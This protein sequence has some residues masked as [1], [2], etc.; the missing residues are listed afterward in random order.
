M[1]G[2]GDFSIEQKLE[3]SFNAGCDIALICDNQKEVQ[4]AINFCQVKKVNLLECPKVL[5]ANFSIHK[6]IQKKSL[7]NAEQKLINL[8]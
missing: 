8:S 2:S 6:N 4:K 1:A 5:K 7:E 3:N